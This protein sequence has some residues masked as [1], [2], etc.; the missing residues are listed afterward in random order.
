MPYEIPFTDSVNKGV[1]VVEDREINDTDTS[2]GLVGKQATGYGQV[3][4]ENFLHMLEN[5]ASINPPANPIEGQTWYD[6]TN[7]VNQ[8]KVYDGTNWVAAGGIKKGNAE[9]LVA[10]SAIGDLWVDT[11]NQQLYLN[12]GA[13]WLLVG[14]EYS[15]GLGSGT[16]ADQILG[17]DDQLYTILKVEISNIPVMIITDSEFTPKAT[18]KGYGTLKPGI[19]I[20]SRILADG[21]LRY[22]GVAEASDSLRVGSINVASTNFIRSDVD[23]SSYGTLR[24]KD[25]GGLEV[26]TN[27]QLTIKTNGE[28][29]VIQSNIS[30]AGIDIN[31]KST[32]G[33]VSTIMRVVGETKNV[34]INNTNPQ[35]SLDVG[36][37]AQVSDNLIVLGTDLAD[38]TFDDTLNEGALQVSGGASIS[39]NVKIGADLLVK[40]ATHIGGH[41]LVDSG[42]AVTPSIGTED[43]PLNEVYAGTFVGSLKGSV[44]GTITGSA[45]SAAKL[46]NRT[47]F[48]IT[49]DVTADDVVFDGSGDL[50][51]TFDI[52]IN[53]E[54]VTTKPD[55]TSLQSGDEIL[56]NRTTG[57][58]T[59]LFK[60]TQTNLFKEVPKNPVGM[61][62]PYAGSIAP[63]NWR[64]CD[65]SIIRKS[66]AFELWETIG[67]SFLSESDI[68][69]LGYS[70]DSYFALPDFRGA[71]LLGAD[72]MGDIA[73]N[74][75]TATSADT[76]GASGGAETKDIKK[77]NLPDHEHDFLSPG[78]IQH[79]AVR[80]DTVA[81]ADEN[82]GNV[83]NVNLTT[84]TST[85]SGIESSG[86]ILNG[87]ASGN[88]SFRGQENLGAALDIMPPYV[89]INYI[90]FAGT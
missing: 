47:T 73:R 12:N 49:G 62:A 45:S 27:T 57:T 89:T 71:F 34:G 72:N 68:Q 46:T 3:V 33:R 56:I 65:G 79:L 75:V 78:G 42:A 31:A 55:I 84:G 14:P 74:R 21:T 11:A 25:N 41:I 30:G 67:H 38:S 64:L 29:A 19:N 59:G 88:G 32:D 18:I 81:D 37:N 52:S 35:E 24:I 23:Q 50:T 7:N 39:Q 44:E 2:I 40:G 63:E 26:G 4:A 90:I 61:I 58:N 20:T 17:T 87:G 54:F 60:I 53:N 9:P 76:V 36:G 6:T 15:G 8:L 48:K 22:N 51:K 5:F 10:N 77:S 28:R 16:V 66:S 1:I 82:S 86:G 70:P 83:A 43:A 85:V 80:D 13:T 69:A